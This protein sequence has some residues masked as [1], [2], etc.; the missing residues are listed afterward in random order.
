LGSKKEI[1]YNIE[2]ALVGVGAYWTGIIIGL[3]MF[4][5]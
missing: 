4:A 1:P 3:V 2:I 5:G